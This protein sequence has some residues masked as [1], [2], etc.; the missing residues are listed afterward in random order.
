MHRCGV[1]IH[2]C[3]HTCTLTF[4]NTCKQRVF[5]D[6]DGNG[7]ISPEESYKS[8]Y[9]KTCKPLCPVNNCSKC[10]V[11]T[12]M[13]LSMPATMSRTF[14]AHDKPPARVDA[15]ASTRL[16]CMS[17][18][19]VQHG[20]WASRSWKTHD[21]LRLVNACQINGFVHVCACACARACACACACT[22]AFVCFP[23]QHQ[24]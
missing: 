11:S 10:C 19:V 6:T 24:P 23:D 5:A 22:R 16:S 4:V 15:A 18:L 20:T 9:R 7:V 1:L 2:A 21:A 3:M 17:V 12:C 14:E 13:R 8:I